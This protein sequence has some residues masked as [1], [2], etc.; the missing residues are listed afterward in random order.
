MENKNLIFDYKNFL[1]N[2]KTERECVS[3]II[4]TAEEAGFKNLYNAES[5]KTG[6]KVYIQKMNKAV[7]LFTIGSEPIEKGMN[8]LGAHI[9]S[10]RL[11]V[12]QKPL[13][14]KDFIVYLNTH[15]Y[16][17][18]KKYQWVTLPLAVHGVV[19]KKD[20]TTVKISIGEDEN[21]PVFCISDILPHLAQEQMKEKASDFISGEN[22]DLI[23]GSTSPEESSD[24]KSENKDKSSA[25]NEILKILKDKYNIDEKDFESAELEVVPAGNARDL[26]LDSSL[27]LAYGQDDRSCA[28][29]SFKALLDSSDFTKTACCLCVDKEE[30]GSV[31]ATGMGSHFFENAVAELIARL[32]GEYSELKLRRCLAESNML[33]SDVNAAYDPMNSNLFDK[34]NA[35]FL[36]GG[37]VFNKYTGSRGKSGASDA[38][39]EF[40][41]KLRSLLDGSQIKYQMA[42]LGK[43]DQGGGG[44]IA[45]LAAKYGMNVLD[46]GVSVL[47]MHAP[48]EIIAKKDIE[49]AYKAYKLFLNLE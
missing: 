40:I 4:K 37:I 42:E 49:Y 15:Y 25:K 12:K 2:G 28:F 21:E 1:N 13:Y 5:L 38:N 22:L 14:E 41:A 31:G 32:P 36:N 33:S 11:D 9:D 18:I 39:P 6:D 34:D 48:W 29:A 16:G 3:Q 35:S 26:G 19:C 47:S 7:A 30:I 45:Y 46:A 23:L 44:T 43:V 10:P 20:G 24:E 17:G 27:I 8:I